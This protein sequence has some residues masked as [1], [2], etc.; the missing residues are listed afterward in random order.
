MNDHTPHTPAALPRVLSIAGTDPTGGA[1]IQADLKSIAAAGG[2]GMSVIT[3]LVAQNT[4]GVRSVHTPGSDFLEQQLSAVFDDVEVDALKIGMLGELATVET[5]SSWL[6]DHPVAHVVLDPVMISTSGHRLLD[7]EAEAAV[8]TLAAEVDVITPNLRELAV[9]TGNDM[10]ETLDG[11]IEQALGFAAAT[12]TIVIVKGGHLRGARADNAV[13]WPDGTCH[14]VPCLRVDTPHTHGTGCSLSAALATRPGAG[15]DVATALEWSTRW[16]HEAI[17]HAA[18]LR[19]GEGNGPVDHSHR[20]RR[21]ARAASSTPW[22]ELAPGYEPSNS[23]PTP[24]IAAAGPHTAELWA[25]TG[26]LWEEIIELP[27]IRGLREGTLLDADFTFYLAQDAAY[28]NGYARALTRLSSQAPD[29]LSQLAWAQ[30]AV[31]TIAVEKELHDSWLSDRAPTASGASAVTMG[32]TNFL[33]ATTHTDSYAV[34]AAAVLPCSWLYAEIGLQLA[35]HNHPQHP[36]RAW[37]ETYVGEEFLEST[38]A[39]LQITE[40][41]LEAATPAERQRARNA[42]LAAAVYER[43]FFDQADRAW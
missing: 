29:E 17:L 12:D 4:R 19:V 43:E 3:S 33:I 15:H 31:D 8:R 39:F 10:A 37:L 14:R 38:R 16:L 26:D 42:Y 13:V 9:L 23:A 20:A 41:A 36:Y 27:F 5:I 22:P 6:R 2:Y 35:K 34:G 24:H 32:Y 21:L 40:Q 1:G 28:L 25:A 7:E 30:A 18:D 11:G